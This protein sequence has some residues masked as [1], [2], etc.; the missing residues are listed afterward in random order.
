MMQK[1]P[2]FHLRHV[3]AFLAIVEHGSIRAAARNM[4]MSQPAFTKTLRELE[5]ALSAPL[6]VRSAQGVTLTDYGRAFWARATLADAE[7]NRAQEEIGQM[8]GAKE[9]T[10]TIG[11]SPVASLLLA[12]D[13][14]AG[15]WKIRPAPNIRII[16]GV[17]DQLILAVGNGSLDFAIGP[18]PKTTSSKIGIEVLFE[19]RIVPVVRTNHPLARTRSIAELRESNWLLTSADADYRKS[20]TDIFENHGLQPPRIAIVCESFP[21]FLELLSESDLV[22]AL[23]ASILTHNVMRNH[24]VEIPLEKPMLVTAMALVRKAQIPLTP[25]AETLATQ[26]RRV[27][28][29]YATQTRAAAVR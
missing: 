26:F 11:L 6:A 2:K 18:L 1:N 12:S 9:G 8:L 23:P 3:R 20:I 25:I 15:F 17:F 19:N 29:R 16:E 24:L 22:A 14:I 28:L 21:G 10:V 13:A 5:N 4:G 7:L 27:G